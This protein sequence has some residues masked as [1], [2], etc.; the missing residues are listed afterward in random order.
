MVPVIQKTLQKKG[1]IKEEEFY[2]LFSVAQ[3]LPGPIALNTSTFVGRSVAGLKGWMAG[4]LGIM[5][6]PFISIVIIAS[7]LGSFGQYKPVQGF[8]QGAFAVVPGL[9]AAFSINMLKKR[10][11]TVPR[12]VL[13]IIAALSLMFSGKW[14]I[15][16]FFGFALL[17]WFVE[18]LNRCSK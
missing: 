15:A 6:P 16:V 17:G 2:S 13:S 3:S 10:K 14:A 18:G 11:W 8:L 9:V 7:L 1:W 5:L 4:F 12:A